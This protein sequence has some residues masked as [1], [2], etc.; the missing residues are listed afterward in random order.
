VTVTDQN[1]RTASDSIRVDPVS[2][3]PPE[4]DDDTDPDRPDPTT[5]RTPT[6]TPSPDGT[7]SP[8]PTATPTPGPCADNEPPTVDASAEFGGSSRGN[9]VTISAF[10]SDPDGEIVSVSYDPARVVAAP[11]P[12]ETTTVRVTATDDCRVLGTDTLVLSGEEATYTR[13]NTN[14]FERKN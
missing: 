11:A 8:T 14:Q 3:D 2:P 10:T 7:A 1:G 13:K 6:S 12:G 9:T 5:D 4:P